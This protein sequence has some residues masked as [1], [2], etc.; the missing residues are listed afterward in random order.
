MD[1]A[2]SIATALAGRIAG[3]AVQPLLGRARRELIKRG[4]KKPRDAASVLAHLGGP[5]RGNLSTLGLLDEL[6]AGVT[7]TQIKH[8]V[9]QPTFTALAR[10]LI[11]IHLCTDD[12]WPIG[13]S[14]EEAAPDRHDVV[15]R[16]QRERIEEALGILL[17]ES[18]AGTDVH[19]LTPYLRALFAALDRG[20]RDVAASMR[21]AL[22]ESDGGF[23][24]AGHT[25]ELAAISSV[26][27]HLA[28]LRNKERASAAERERWQQEYLDAFLY[29]NE[30]I[31]LPDLELRTLIPYRE[32]FVEP[33]AAMLEM[34]VSGSSDTTGTREPVSRLHFAD[35]LDALDRTVILGDPGAGKSTVSQVLACQ[36]CE[37]GRGVAFLLKVRQ[38]RFSQGGVNLV[39]EIERALRDLYQKPAPP[40]MVEELLLNGSALVIF[41]GLDEVPTTVRGRDVSDVIE[42]AGNAYPLSRFV[43]TSRRLGYSSVRLDQELFCDYVLRPFNDGQVKEYVGKWFVRRAGGRDATVDQLVENFMEHSNT[44]RDLRQNPLMLAVIC[45]LH[46]GYNEIPRSR[47]KIYK[48]CVELLLRTWDSHRGIGDPVWDIEAFEVVLAEIAYHTL[49][50][51]EY[52]YGM[53]ESQVREVAAKNLLQEAVPDRATAMQLAR[54]M[55]DL[56]RGRAWMF[57]DVVGGIPGE[58][59]YSFTHQSF[60]EYFAA[61]YLVRHADSPEQ[62]GDEIARNIVSGRLEIFSQI[63]LSLAS[64]KFQ[65]GAS[66]VYHHCLTANSGRSAAEEAALVEFLAKSA[67]IVMLNGSALQLTADRVVQ[68]LTKG[69]HAQFAK[70]LLRADFR[71]ADSMQGMVAQAFVR[72]RDDHPSE[73]VRVMNTNLWAWE[74]CLQEGVIGLTGEVGFAGRLS[75]LFEGGLYYLRG[76]GESCTAMWLMRR[77][78]DPA[79]DPPTR[80]RCARILEQLAAITPDDIVPEDAPTPP[81]ALFKGSERSSRTVSTAL[82]RSPRYSV[83]A[84][85]GLA[86]LTMAF[87]ELMAQNQPGVI[88]ESHSVLN[89]FMR[90][91]TLRQPGRLPE[92]V[93]HLP[94]KDQERI[95]SW[96]AGDIDF[97]EWADESVAVS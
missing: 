38:I 44:I 70:H 91:R 77:L 58:E 11:A 59:R 78:A 68:C 6:P 65:Y 54:R 43:V 29:R 50:T 57:S 89:D 56:C 81:Y 85:A 28:A 96:A 87:C 8:I 22:S 53:T 23:S 24:W 15:W 25:L 76:G 84:R 35:M 60:R 42:A 71:H 3:E 1:P 75:R 52:Q 30:K 26:E 17:S 32:I 74:N 10:Q 41:D 66:L 4:V 69:T 40:G 31:E 21:L 47:P 13:E 48:K 20:C 2:S 51:P 63:C 82:L 46:A 83:D 49:L 12:P 37:R 80:D 72:F 67:D 55:I 33:D 93:S 19:A 7:D 86:Y 90:A 34:D 64:G 18:L 9:Q 73:F 27:R 36:W 79:T 61:Q 16:V 95:A 88:A 62:V 45:L 92:G 14:R 94:R 39:E 5:H 97:F